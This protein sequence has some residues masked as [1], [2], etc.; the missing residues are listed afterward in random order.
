MT[1]V[2]DAAGTVVATG[3]RLRL[4]TLGRIPAASAP[5]TRPDELRPGVLHLGLGAFHRAHQ[6]VYTE[7]AMAAAGGDWG[8]VAVAPRSRDVLTR[9]TAQDGLFSVLTLS[10]GPPTARVVGAITELRHAASAP[11][12][13]VD[14]LADP[15][16]RVVTLTVTEKAY[17]LTPATG[18]LQADDAVTADLTTGRPPT[19]LPG[20][21]A[22]GLLARYRADAGPLAVVSCD[23]LPANG[24]LL[25]AAIR[26]AVELAGPPAALT[27]LAENVTFPATMVDRIVPAAT[28]ETVAT[29]RAVLGV[30][31]LATVSA[32]PFSQ[33][34]IEDA[35][36]AG[37]PA[38]DQVGAVL[39]DDVAPWERLKLRVLNGVHSTLAY[40]GALDGAETVADA[41]TRPGMRAVLTRLV[42]EDVAPTLSP[43]PGVSVDDYAATVLERFGNPAIGHRTL[44]I[45]MDGSQK[46]PQRLLG[47]L[48]DLRAVGAEPRW[49]ALSLAAWMRFV[50]G[51]ADDGRELPLSDPKAELL[52]AALAAAP[53][54]PDGVASALLGCAEVVPP[55]LAD[56]PVVRGLVTEWLTVLDRHG[57]TGALDAAG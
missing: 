11:M 5:L 16:I 4:D 27:W 13:I 7:A 44:Q 22:R 26:Q 50:R 55:A 8:I 37:R 2:S 31:D 12:A 10:A 40:L 56:D 24:R 9:L 57:V 51:R 36:P 29:T 54:T 30:T 47:T 23:N 21:L 39:T 1:P 25:G 46:L 49:A 33:W 32:E 53:D 41:L 17:R 18:R 43:P 19:T 14:R 35:F 34:V 28:A 6:A 20:L 42:A 52:R 48:A 15:E 45:A 3:A 38:W